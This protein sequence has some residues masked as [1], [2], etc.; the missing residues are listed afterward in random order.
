M[1]RQ[2]LTYKED[3]EQGS[4][5][6]DRTVILD[7]DN[8]KEIVYKR[9]VILTFSKPNHDVLM[10]C[11]IYDYLV[12]RENNETRFEERLVHTVNVW[13]N[14]YDSEHILLSSEQQQMVRALESGDIRGELADAMVNS[15]FVDCIILNPKSRFSEF[16][17]KLYERI[18][19]RELFF[20]NQRISK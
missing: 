19:E 9:A 15:L 14:S 7:T 12:I 16:V 5:D 1:E 8:R 11:K 10:C 4:I 6:F 2:P 3:Y 20:K 13:C 17:P 18:V